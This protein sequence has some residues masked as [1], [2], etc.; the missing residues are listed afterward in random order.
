MLLGRLIVE[1][2]ACCEGD[3]AVGI[4]LE[5][6]ARVATGD[7]VDQVIEGVVSGVGISISKRVWVGG[8]DSRQDGGVFDRFGNAG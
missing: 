7:G 8:R 2:L 1:R 6:P 4:D 3:I 5:Q